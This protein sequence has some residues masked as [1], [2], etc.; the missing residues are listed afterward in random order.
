M[1]DDRRKGLRYRLTAA[2]KGTWR[3]ERRVKGGGKITATLGNYP[4][5]T[6][7]AARKLALELEAEAS[8]GINR[9]EDAKAEKAKKAL[10]QSV[11]DVLAVYV[12]QHLSGLRQGDERRRQLEASLSNVL[13]AP[14]AALTRGSLQAAVDEK[15]S[16]GKHAM[17][18]R[19]AAALKAFTRWAFQRGYLETDIGAGVAKSGREKSV[20]AFFRWMRSKPFGR[21]AATWARSGGR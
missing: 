1:S 7:A 17:A 10:Q 4:A 3:Y 5:V 16:A 18:N 20:N 11:G 19:V 14:M 2:G 15:L 13:Q 6:L 12:E 8:Q 21:Q 9:F